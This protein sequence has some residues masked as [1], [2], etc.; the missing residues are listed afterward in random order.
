MRSGEKQGRRSTGIDVPDLFPLLVMTPRGRIVVVLHL[1]EPELWPEYREA[2]DKISEPF[3]LF[4]TLTA[5]MSEQTDDLVREDFP[6]AQV[7]TFPDFGR[8]IFPFVSLINSGVL[9]RYEL[10]CRVNGGGRPEPS[11]DVLRDTDRVAGILSA[12][13]ADPDLGIVVADAYA[14][15]GETPTQANLGQINALCRNLGLPEIDFALA[16]P[17]FP[18]GSDFWIRPFLLRMIGSL[19]LDADDFAFWRHPIAGTAAVAIDRLLG[20]V[21]DCANM[22]VATASAAEAPRSP[23]RSSSS[24]H[25][26]TIAFYLPQFHPIPENDLWWGEGFTEWTNVTR[27]RPQFPGHRQPR[28]PSELGFTDLRLAEVREAQAALAKRYGISAFC[29]HYYWFDGQPLLRRP[30]DEVL[31]SGKP[32]FPFLLCWANEP[33]TRGW[34]GKARAILMPQEYRSGWV[35]ALARDI[36]P[37]L[38]DQRY[39]RFLGDPVF[40]V[41]RPMDIPARHATFRELRAALADL[42]VPR[43]HLVG[44]WPSFP[45]DETLPDDPAAVGLDAYVEFRPRGLTKQ[46]RK[47][48]ELADADG[49]FGGNIIYLRRRDR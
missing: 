42:G 46:C 7:I 28:L 29:Y 41:Y 31:T 27:A 21:C 44:T 49:S 5:G 8:D 40:L 11:E 16:R 43:I 47:V 48:V 38:R 18:V 35:A 36:A 33:W 10:V 30:L 25:V 45:G 13:D 9:F 34:D 37:V 39:F 3:D 26:H 22:R 20:L 4:V 17:S 19:K 24:P 12:F 6:Y 23:N 1:R 2:L 15:K 14:L 32:D